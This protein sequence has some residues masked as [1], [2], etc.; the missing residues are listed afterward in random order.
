MINFVGFLNKCSLKVVS[1]KSYGLLVFLCLFFL[2]ACDKESSGVD[3]MDAIEFAVA[4][5]DAVVKGSELTTDNINSFGVFA[6]LEEGNDGFDSVDSDLL[7]PFMTDVPVTR[8]DGKWAATPQHY[9][10]I[11]QDKYLSF[12]AYAPHSA[13]TGIS[14]KAGWEKESGVSEPKTVEVTYTLDSNPAKHVDLCVASAVLDRARDN[15][16]DGKSDP[17]VFDFK[18]TLA[19]VSFAANYIGT[20]PEGCYLRIDEL[21]VGKMVN[22]NKLVYNS[23]KK[24]YFTWDPITLDTVRDGSYV[25]NIGSR[26]LSSNQPII[27]KSDN[28]SGE[29]TYT[30]FVTT[31]G[32]IYALPQEVNPVGRPI[33]TKIDVTFSYVKTES[34]A[35]IAQFYTSVDL[36]NSTLIVARKYK[37][38]FTLDV[39]NTSL[40]SISCV[41][42]G[43]WIIDW[44]NS[45]NSHSDTLIK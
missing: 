2:L 15:D 40:I 27:K 4:D 33:I 38:L 34:D 26:T 13:G 41:D 36:P 1:S 14:A 9:W 45:N 22:T 43:A 8:K 5:Y 28:S 6:A 30:D 32:L 35:P 18:H 29:V 37:Y 39:T 7:Q 3:S 12:F 16:G 31:N 24:D 11:L 42:T 23:E 17:I 10:P 25:L 44:K 20:L 19:S 21:V